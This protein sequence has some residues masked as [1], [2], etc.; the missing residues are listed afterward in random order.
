MVRAPK[1][2]SMLVVMEKALP[3]SSTMEM[4][5]VPP[6]STG[7][8]VAESALLHVRRRAGSDVRE[9]AVRIDQG[10]AFGEIAGSSSPPTG[11]GTKSVSAR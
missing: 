10:A 1:A 9:G 11:T 2:C 3:S 8:V 4:W 7:R 6:F 5:L